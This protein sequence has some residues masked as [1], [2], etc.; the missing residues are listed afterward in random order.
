M[1][2]T[3]TLT[4]LLLWFIALTVFANSGIYI[5]GHFRRDR[6]RT[7]PALKASGYTFGIFF[8]VHVQ[9]DGTLVTDG[10]TI[11]KDGEYVFGNTSPNY[12]DDVNSLLTGNTSI[13]RLEHCIGGWGNDAYKNITNLVKASEADGGGTGPNSILYRNFKALK[14]AIPAVIAINND[15]EQDYD[16]ETQA[17]F[18]IMLYDLG[19]KTTI[20]PYTR[21]ESYWVPFV[22]Q[23]N[24]AR[25]GAVDRNYLQCYGGGANNKPNDWKIG[26]L[27]I[28][29]SRDIES[30]GYTH[31]QI[32]DVMTNWKNDAGIVG[33][34]YWSYNWNRNL[35]AEAAPINEVFGGGEIAYRDQ[36]VAM[37]YPVTDYKSPQVDFSMGAYTS[38][39]INA[40]GFNPSDLSAIK[41]KEGI[42]MILYTEDD[43]TGES[44]EITSDT[45]NITT[46][47]GERDIK[48]WTIMADCIESLDGKAFY[49]KNKNSGL[50][51]KP[52]TN[53]N[54]NNTSMQQRPNDNTDYVVWSFEKVKD[55]LYKITNKG[56][57]KVLTV[58]ESRI[59]DAT[60]MEQNAYSGTENQHF[61]VTYD[62]DSGA[63]HLIPLNS[64]KYVGVSKGNE[65]RANASIQQRSRTAIGTAWEL[66]EKSEESGLK[67]ITSKQA[68]NVYPRIVTDNIFVESNGVS[69]TRIT[70]LDQ[71]GR[72]L[73]EKENIENKINVSSLPKGVYLLLIEGEGLDKPVP[74]KIVK[75]SIPI[76]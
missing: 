21:R 4:T 39:Q 61:I 71:S 76:K 60:I 51:L 65:T 19:F 34:F 67:D 46:V 8:N 57:D 70:I 23:I 9:A 47:V 74:Y 14:D 41:L 24:K 15:I 73:I 64:L 35:Q 25:P 18:H 12:V 68:F 53:G 62:E 5:C 45:P 2:K 26:G 55:G 30:N 1:K 38:G 32:V 52:S 22:D 69:I 44:F 11:C 59:Y 13:L 49:I 28:Y 10:E 43:N 72:K 54:N 33:G 17:R 29:G 75:I 40:K 58:R 48:S 7:V 66:L 27:P 56:N 20:A 3:K 16:Y 6:T 37:V 36:I 63:Y 31:Q 50:L 42:K